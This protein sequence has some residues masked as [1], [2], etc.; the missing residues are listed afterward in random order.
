MA[1]LVLFLLR[2]LGSGP[3]V[4]GPGVVGDECRVIPETAAAAR[5]LDQGAVPAGFEDVLGAVP[6]DQRERAG[7]VG[8]AIVARRG[9][10]AQQL[11]QI[12]LVGRPFAAVAG[13][14]D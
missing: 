12:L 6:L 5:L 1:D 7:V 8:T 9:Y 2:E 13:R 11:L 3:L 4:L 14:V 10:L